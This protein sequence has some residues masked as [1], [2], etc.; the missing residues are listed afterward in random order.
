MSR[1]RSVLGLIARGP[2][3]MRTLFHLRPAQARAQIQHALFGL[4]VPRDFSGPTPSLAIDE[5]ATPFLGPPEHVRLPG[6][7]QIEMLGTTF[8]LALPIDWRSQ[9]AGPLFAYHLHQ[10]EVLRLEEFPKSLRE[11]FLRDW[12]RNHPAGIG[13]DPHPISLRLFCWGKLLTTPG[14]FDERASDAISGVV[15]GVDDVGGG[16]QEG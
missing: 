14:L 8:D 5:I 13:W 9:A 16:A 2:T 12:I 1:T 4:P 7:G 3:V 15:H 6:P 10:H 11:A